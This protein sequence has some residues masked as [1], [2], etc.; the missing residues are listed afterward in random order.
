MYAKNVQ[1]NVKLVSDP[2][3]I[4]VYPA[5]PLYSTMNQVPNVLLRPNVY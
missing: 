2:I 3:M 5:K 4:T 1:V